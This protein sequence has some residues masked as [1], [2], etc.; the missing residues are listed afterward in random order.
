[1][2]AV[3]KD[4]DGLYYPHIHVRDEMWLK[5]TLLYF[6]HVLR[7]VP[8]DFEVMDSDTVKPLTQMEGARGEPLLGPYTLGTPAT[9]A[10]VDRLITRLKGDIG[11]TP[12]LTDRFSRKTT[13]EQNDG[14]DYVFLIHRGNAPEDFWTELT[15]L[16]LVWSP[17][18]LPDTPSVR[19]H[20]SQKLKRLSRPDPEV[21]V[22]VHPTFGETFMATVAAAAAQDVGLEVVTDSPHLHRVASCR[23]E[24][25][26]YRT[27]MHGDVNYARS[28]TAMTLR[29]A[30]LV[31]VGA[32]NVSELE[33]QKLAEMSKNRE[34]LFDFRHYLA[35]RVA[36]IPQ[37][38]SEERRE[39]HLKAAA[40]EALSEWR[41]SLVN[42]S[43]FAR[44]FFGVGLL[45]KSEKPMTDLANALIPGC[46]T[47]VATAG[48]AAGAA[49]MVGAA[50]LATSPLVV[51]APGLAVALAIY[52]VK[53]WHGLKQEERT[54]SFRYLSLL[55]DKSAILFAAPPPWL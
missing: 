20:L 54:S 44:R 4:T 2:G 15:Q 53:T 19:A 43:T 11:T 36:E 21:W 38:D 27:L 48:G 8:P 33:L 46:L 12:H 23:N 49:P 51:A 50:T 6:P 13:L 22:A 30:Q 16:G 18:E 47:T 7:M 29:L 24:E 35:E 9:V 55:K 14:R 37:M 28:E 10:A 39:A 32:F 52:G 17:A 45:D 40:E 5:T 41:K 1:M 3:V 42:M 31:I 34:A 26:A 25:I